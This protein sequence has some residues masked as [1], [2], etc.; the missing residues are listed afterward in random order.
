[1]AMKYALISLNDPTPSGLPARLL[2]MLGYISSTSLYNFQG[3]DIDLGLARND[4]AMSYSPC[5]RRWSRLPTLSCSWHIVSPWSGMVEWCFLIGRKCHHCFVEPITVILTSIHTSTKRPFMEKKG[6]PR[7]S[8]MVWLCLVFDIQYKKQDKK[9]RPDHALVWS[10]II[11]SIELT[12]SHV[13]CTCPL[14]CRLLEVLPEAKLLFL[15]QTTRQYI[16]SL[17]S[18]V[19]KPRT[20]KNIWCFSC[21]GCL[22]SRNKRIEP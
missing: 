12:V 5:R 4:C 7:H 17:F 19:S 14:E 2:S 20:D 13:M 21:R 22:E 8:F 10:E 18:R 9:E 6:E 3:Y 15:F 11:M 1:M 16:H